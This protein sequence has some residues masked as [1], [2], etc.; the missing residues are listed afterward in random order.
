MTVELSKYVE[1]NVVDINRRL[2]FNSCWLYSFNYIND[3]SKF[4]KMLIAKSKSLSIIL[5]SERANKEKYVE[6]LKKLQKTDDVEII[7][8][9]SDMLREDKLLVCMK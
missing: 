9:F 5:P 6:L 1:D 4:A 8:L 7:I 3:F 2:N